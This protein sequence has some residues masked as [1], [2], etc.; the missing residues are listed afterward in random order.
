MNVGGLDCTVTVHYS[1]ASTI[2][3]DPTLP[4][5]VTVLEQHTTTVNSIIIYQYQQSG[6]TPSVP[7]LVC[8]EDERWSSDP[9]Q[10]VCVMLNR[11]TLIKNT[12][13]NL[14]PHSFQ[15]LLYASKT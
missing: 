8:T 15:T 1:S 10:V 5:G 13:V 2:D 11:Y 9:T 6:F 7:S 12:E 4:S 3:C 14:Y